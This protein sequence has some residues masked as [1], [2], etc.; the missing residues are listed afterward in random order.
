MQIPRTYQ[1]MYL[2][3]VDK[4]ENVE[5]DEEKIFSGL[6]LL[7]MIDLQQGPVCACDSSGCAKEK[8]KNLFTN[9]L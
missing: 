9:D 6:T 7:G 1:M 8:F 4:L 2:N 3:N 5:Q